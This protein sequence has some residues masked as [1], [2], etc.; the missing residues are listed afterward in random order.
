MLED[1]SSTDLCEAAEDIEEDLL[2][3]LLPCFDLVYLQDNEDLVSEFFLF[4][5]NWGPVEGS[6][7]EKEI[8]ESEELSIFSRDFS[9]KQWRFQISLAF[10]WIKPEIYMI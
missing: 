1:I 6:R 3:R 4:F 9:E 10:A 8:E 7:D 5:E 2:E